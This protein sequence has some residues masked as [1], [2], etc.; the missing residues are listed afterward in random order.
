L[1]NVYWDRIWWP[2]SCVPFCDHFL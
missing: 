2:C 1:F